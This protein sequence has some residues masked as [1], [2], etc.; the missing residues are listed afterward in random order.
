MK[1]KPIYDRIILKEIKK[2]ENKTKS[3]I[4]LPASVKEMP[5]EGKI[6]AIDNDFQ[7][8]KQVR[9]GLKK[10]DIVLYPSYSAMEFYFELA[11]N[12]LV[13]AETFTEEKV[14]I[15]WFRIYQSKNQKIE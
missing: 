2:K 14:Y 9:A 3:G 1:L 8:D 5:C 4:I 6:I 7:N 13:N 15:D 11:I 10:G 12:D